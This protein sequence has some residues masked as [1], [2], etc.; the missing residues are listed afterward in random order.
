MAIDDGSSVQKVPYPKLKERLLADGQVLEF[1]RKPA[2]AAAKQSALMAADLRGIVVDDQQAKLTGDWQ[3]SSAVGPFVGEGYLHDGNGEKGKRSAR[4]EANL[5]KAGRYEVRVI[6][7]ANANRATN[8]PVTVRYGGGEKVVKLN[9]RQA[10]AIDGAWA[11]LGTFE[12]A[13]GK[14]AVVEVANDG[15]DGHVIVDAVQFLPAK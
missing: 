8:V 5:P 7:S 12:F 3:P 14:A 1:A 15:T 13:A 10:P 4:F 9:Q 6:Y 11:A 2:P